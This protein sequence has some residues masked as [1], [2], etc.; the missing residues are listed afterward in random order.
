MRTVLITGAGGL[1]GGILSERL[2]D[3]YS[4]RLVDRRRGADIG[5]VDLT[6]RRGL[7]SVFAGV[8]AVID[9][10]AIPSVQTRWDDVW[11]NNIPA[12]V[13]TLEAAREAGVERVVFASS[14][15]VTGGYEHDDPYAAI[16]AGRYGN[17]TP[18]E[19]PLIAP[20]WP[21]RPDGAYALGK[22][23]GE[24]AARY[25]SDAFELSVVCLRIGT[26]NEQGRPR[27]PREFATL[28]THDDLTR[29]VDAALQAPAS[30]RCGVYYGVSDNTWRFWDIA[31]A[32]SELGYEP[33]DNAERFRDGT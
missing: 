8:D 7:R 1:V 32:H 19:F 28:L 14:N 30:V 18:G 5:R 6:K 16:V 21:V 26:V 25:Y 17:L 15:H 22:V 29:L 23:L 20:D 4:L 9:L 27:A 31:N 2:A 10:A 13:N 24:A 3:E 12:T 33:Q 11:K